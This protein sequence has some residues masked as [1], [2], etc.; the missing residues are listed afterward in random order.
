VRNAE[1]P[2][3]RLRFLS[4]SHQLKR[5]R[6]S[7]LL[8]HL[9]RC[10]GRST[11]GRRLASR[12]KVRRLSHACPPGPSKRFLPWRVDL[13]V[14]KSSPTSGGSN[15]FHGQKN[16]PSVDP[17][18][19]RRVPASRAGERQSSWQLSASTGE[20]RFTPV[21]VSGVKAPVESTTPRVPPTLQSLI[22]A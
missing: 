8:A 22:P 17:R 19:P 20:S 21:Q 7:R 16:G 5:K 4:Q 14:P 2:Q 3:G 10:C 12:N 15:R 9:R 18:L 13:S 6:G 11:C 1:L